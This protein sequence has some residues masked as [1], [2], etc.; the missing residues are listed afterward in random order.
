[1]TAK[2]VIPTRLARQDVEDEL[3]HYLVDEGSE[4]AALGFIAEIEQAYAHLA[5][6]PN[7]GSLRYS[8]ELDIPGLRSWSLDRYPHLIFYIERKDHVEVWRVLNGKRDIPAWLLSDD[9][10]FH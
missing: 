3:T 6:H 10:E 2:A 4:Q 1:M 5:K 7:I 9:S 8:Y